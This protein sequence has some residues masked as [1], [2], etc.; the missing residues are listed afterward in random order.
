MGYKDLDPLKNNAFMDTDI[1]TDLINNSDWLH[2]SAVQVQRTI[3][4]SAARSSSGTKF[5][6]L[7]GIDNVAA[8]KGAHFETVK[9]GATQGSKTVPSIVI[10]VFF[11]S[12]GAN[13]NIVVT[14][15]T[16]TSF[17]CRLVPSSSKARITGG[18]IHWMAMQ[19]IV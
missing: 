16:T 13:V 19:V 6:L 3:G 15:I 18:K 11:H 10:P 7:H 1:I 2:D 8:F 17:T 4:T 5:R 12:K 9:F 14:K